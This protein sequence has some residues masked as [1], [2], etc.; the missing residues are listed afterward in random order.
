MLDDRN[1]S[2][3]KKAEEPAP[4][5]FGMHIYLYLM[6]A[7]LLLCIGAFLGCFWLTNSGYP[8]DWQMFA[9]LAGPVLVLAIVWFALARCSIPQFS[10]FRGLLYMT[11]YMSSGVGSYAAIIAVPAVMVG[12]V[13]TVAI[14]AGPLVSTDRSF[15]PRHFG[16]FLGFYYRH[17]MYQ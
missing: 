8:E 17:R 16:R 3:A 9:A 4:A 1:A 10:G 7:I 6:A 15:A 11:A 12:I 14:A 2:K 5:R 13:G